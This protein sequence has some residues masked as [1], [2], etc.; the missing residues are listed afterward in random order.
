MKGLERIAGPGIK[1]RRMAVGS[2]RC[3]MMFQVVL[4]IWLIVSPF[5]LGFQE[6]RSMTLN[7]I[8]LGTVVAIFGLVIAFLALPEWW[9]SEKKIF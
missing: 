8:I 7:D 4:G 2:L 1:R 6:I 5:A 3:W 9:H